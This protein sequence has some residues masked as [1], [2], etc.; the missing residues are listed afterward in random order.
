MQAFFFKD[1]AN[2][3][4]PEILEEIYI[5]RI[6]DPFFIQKLDT[7]VDIGANIGL[8]AHYFSS[9]ADRVFAVE[10]S[11]V[12]LECLNKMV[13]YNKIKNVKVI[14][15]AIYIKESKMPL[16]HN[17]NTTAFSMSEVMSRV[18]E[19]ETIST[20]TIDKLFEDNKIE[21]CNFMKLDVEGV[22]GEIIHHSGFEKVAPKIGAMIVEYHDWSGYNPLN[23]ITT[24]RD[25]GFKNVDFIK[26]VKATLIYAIRK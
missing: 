6:Y 5:N 10:P 2:S 19:K 7:V 21:H 18:K 20:I 17:T 9:R 25:Y 1:F 14:D 26:N 3:Y 24:L 16:Y 13:E 23:I 11:A 8:T 12:H 15:K 4:L 22:E